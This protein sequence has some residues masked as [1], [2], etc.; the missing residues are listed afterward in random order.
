MRDRNM[1]GTKA[2]GMK[3]AG[4]G[5]GT[6]GGRRRFDLE[7]AE[8]MA[9]AALAFLAEDA[10]QLGHFLS[11]TGLGPAELRAEAGT[12]R[13]LAAVLEHMLGDEALLLTFTA[14]CGYQPDDVTPAWDALVYE[15]ARAGREGA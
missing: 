4:T 11:L 3:T 10:T 1:T 8:G 14:N 6:G 12:P 5:G 15:A 2:L 13:M 7:A 9:I